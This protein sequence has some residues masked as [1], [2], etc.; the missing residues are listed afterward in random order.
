MN[1]VTAETPRRAWW[2]QNEFGPKAIGSLKAG[3]AAVLSVGLADLL[4]LTHA[5]W[6]AVSAMVVMGWEDTLTFASCRDRIL[7]TAIGAL[8]GWATFYIWHG[9]YLLYGV[10]AA[11]CIFA[12]S[13]LKFDKAGRLAAA[14]L[15]IIVLVP[16]DE[17]PS[18]IALSRFLEVGIGVSMALL[19]TFLPPRSAK[20]D[21]KPVA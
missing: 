14:T 6:A 15:T 12:C 5:Y 9:H 19:M 11:L 1:L 10:S 3:L 8:M 21:T 17:P 7:G 13:A 16:I 4:G 18:R 2:H 20:P